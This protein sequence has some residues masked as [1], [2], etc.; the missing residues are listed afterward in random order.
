MG[1]G[2][3]INYCQSDGRITKSLSYC[4]VR[5]SVGL[6]AGM[7]SG[8]LAFPDHAVMFAPGDDV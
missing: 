8:G 6:L 3:G 5:Q 7:D 1:E 2:D 4:I